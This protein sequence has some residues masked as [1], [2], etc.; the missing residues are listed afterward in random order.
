[1]LPVTCRPGAS[2][3]SHDP[4]RALAALTITAS[5][6]A[7]ALAAAPP[8][9]AGGIGDF[10]SPSF[11]TDCANWDARAHAAGETT[12]GTGTAN[13]NLLGLP[14][15]SPTNQCGGA[16][17]VLQNEQGLGALAGLSPSGPS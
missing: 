10:L 9:S 14:L 16:D 11:G 1:M 8:A 2:F 12:A 13:S 5:A 7:A 15:G 3:N 17:Q 6:A 4:R